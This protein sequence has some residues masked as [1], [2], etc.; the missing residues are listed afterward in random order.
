MNDGRESKDYVFLE[1]TQLQCFILGEHYCLAPRSGD[2]LRDEGA[3]SY[4][5]N[6]R[7]FQSSLTFIA[8]FSEEENASGVSVWFGRALECFHYDFNYSLKF[9]KDLFPT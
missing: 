9:K 8:N 1:R 3:M 4:G 6:R 2:W 5:G 7:E